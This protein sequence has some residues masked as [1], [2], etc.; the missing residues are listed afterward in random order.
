[1]KDFKLSTLAHIEKGKQIDTRQ[2]TECGQYRY[3]N[4]G[5]KESGF[6]NAFNSEGACVLISEGGAS[7]GY[8]NYVNERFWCGCHCYRLY[9]TKVNTKYLFYAL[10]AR[11]NKIMSLRTGAAMPNIK[12]KSLESFNV[13]VNEELS[14]QKR[15]V[16][17]LETID[18]FINAKKKELVDLNLLVKSRFNEMFMMDG[19]D[20]YPLKTWNDVATIKHGRDYKK[21]ISDNSGYPV[22]GSGGFMGVYADSY[23]V[24]EKSTLC[25]RKGTI[26]KPIFAKEK[27]WNVDTAFGIEP[28]SKVLDPVYFFYRAILYDYKSFSTSTTLPSMTKDALERLAIGVPP[29]TLQKEFASFVEL[30]DKSKFIVQQQIK[31]LQELLNSKMEEF[32][33]EE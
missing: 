9:E 6:Y 7:C 2:V 31:D 16:N 4:G 13:L 18:A 28:N 24:K 14:E 23:L 10:K 32:F 12:K 26:D 17:I 25:G 21:N 33:G 20:K 11:Q 19:N 27:I 1:M 5:I 29:L 3:I 8:V 22:Y 15:V 30:I